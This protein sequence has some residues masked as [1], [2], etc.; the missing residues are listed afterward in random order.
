MNNIKVILNKEFEAGFRLLNNWKYALT[1]HI[2]NKS[3][4]SNLK[5]ST[6]YKK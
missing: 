4:T 3:K 2:G 1:A 6:I 5:L